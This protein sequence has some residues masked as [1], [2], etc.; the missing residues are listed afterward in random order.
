MLY[1]VFIIILMFVW[2][3]FNLWNLNSYGLNSTYEDGNEN[4]ILVLD[5]YRD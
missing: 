2:I 1:F 3:H 4:K 5:S